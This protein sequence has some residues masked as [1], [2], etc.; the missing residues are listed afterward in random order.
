MMGARARALAPLGREQLVV[1]RLRRV[2]GDRYAR[3]GEPRPDRVE[4]RVAGAP[5]VHETGECTMRAPRASRRSSSAAAI[6][7][8]MRDNARELLGLD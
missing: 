6:R 7:R 2:I 5:A 1:A 3:F 8:I 4:R